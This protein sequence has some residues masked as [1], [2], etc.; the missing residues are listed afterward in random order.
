LFI[1]IIG[2]VPW[3][4][5][6]ST[7]MMLHGMMCH[8]TH[9]DLLMYNSGPKAFPL[10]VNT[11]QGTLPDEATVKRLIR[12]GTINRVFTPMVCGTAF[13]NKGVQPLLD[14]VAE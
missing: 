14:A 11:L 6:I 2:D 8:S 5:W 12:K 3:W 9:L 13:K 7:A 1:I 4:Q 10:F